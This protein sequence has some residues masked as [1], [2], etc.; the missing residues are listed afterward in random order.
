MTDDSVTT[1]LNS[2]KNDMTSVVLQETLSAAGVYTHIS[3]SNSQ[4]KHSAE[5]IEYT[6]TVID[7]STGQSNVITMSLAEKI[8]SMSNDSVYVEDNPSVE[9]QLNNDSSIYGGTIRIN[10][11]GLSEQEK[12]DLNRS[13]TG[14]V[15]DFAINYIKNQIH[16]DN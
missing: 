11:P 8:R 7:A 13:L 15:E 16:K 1:I 5:N 9:F 12:K 2:V 6:E 3:D 4:Y 14:L 10:T